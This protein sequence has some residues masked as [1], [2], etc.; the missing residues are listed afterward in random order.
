M[1]HVIGDVIT[2]AATVDLIVGVLVSILTGVLAVLVVGATVGAVARVVVD[3]VYTACI[4]L[5][6]SI[7]LVDEIVPVHSVRD[8][9]PD[10]PTNML[11]F[12][13]VERTQ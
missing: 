13:A 4:N 7:I 9:D 12:R 6:T 3:M 11:Y 5:F 1:G 10:E 8:I 2:D